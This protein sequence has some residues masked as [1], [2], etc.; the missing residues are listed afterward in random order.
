MTYKEFR[1]KVWNLGFVVAD[2]GQYWCVERGADIFA[3]IDLETENSFNTMYYGS[4]Q[5]DG[6]LFKKILEPIIE[7]ASTPLKERKVETTKYIIKVEPEN[8]G[9]EFW[10]VDPQQ[11]INDMRLSLHKHSAG[12]FSADEAEAIKSKVLRHTNFCKATILEAE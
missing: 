12:K 3:K 8:Y 7:F 2:Q 9:D 6:E 11:G 4:S 10:V 1:D 5:I